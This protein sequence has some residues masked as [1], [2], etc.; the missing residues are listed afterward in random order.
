MGVTQTTDDSNAKGQTMTNESTS[1]AIKQVFN[2]LQVKV[3][4]QMASGMSM[5]VAIGDVFGAFEQ[6]FPELAQKLVQIYYM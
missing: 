3:A 1:E 6:Q 5:E 4:E 2:M